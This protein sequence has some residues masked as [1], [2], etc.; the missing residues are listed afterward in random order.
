MEA[1]P[2]AS[3]TTAIPA[4]RLIRPDDPRYDDARRVWNGMIDH[5][6]AVI[7]QVESTDDVVAAIAL[8]RSEGLPVSIRG[9]GHNVAGLAVGDGAL[10]VDLAAMARVAVDPARRRA[11][12]GAGA[13]WGALD[14][15][16]QAHGLATP[17]GVVS[18]TGIAGLTLSGG[19]GWLRRKHGLSCDALRAVTLVTADGRV[20]RASADEHPDLFWGLRGG[21]GNFGVVTEFE[22][23]LFPVGPM[24][25]TTVAIWPLEDAAARLRDFRDLAPNLPDE[26]SPVAVL[27]PVPDDEAF[28]AAI[29]GGDALFI[30]AMAA[31]PLDEGVELVRPIAELGGGPAADIG[32]PTPY[33][34]FQ[35]F[36]DADYPAHTM[37]YYWKSSFA[38]DLTDERIDRLV[39][40]F[41]R[42]PSHHS[43]ID[44][45]ANLGAISRVSSDD[46][47]FGQRAEA[48][49]ISP[50]SNWESPDDDAANLAWGRDIVDGIGG[51]AYLNFPG[52]LEEGEQQSRSSHGPTFARL[53]AVK[54]AWDPDNVFR[55]NANITPASRR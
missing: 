22:F 7:A 19:L 28:P 50:E 4:E 6:P 37:R 27:S 18:V 3:A 36:F 39:E 42:R 12:V 23:E 2:S 13:R 25:A 21:G 34:E 16:A 1:A 29:R 45:W 15:A 31:A 11:T 44:I 8:A 9:G 46:S 35:Q 26:V 30:L 52:L 48:W 54:A 51:S 33:V 53:A 24:V 55:F 47:A 17:G 32:G 38:D 41:G 20:V 10:M 14:A 5:R 49:L 43:T 40:A